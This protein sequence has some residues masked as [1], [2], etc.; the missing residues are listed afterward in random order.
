MK[1]RCAIF[2]TVKNENIFLPIWL[3]HYQQY[4]SNEDI[5]VLDHHST[6]GSTKNLPV[7]VRL[8]SNDTVNDNEWLRNIAQ[9][10]QRELLEKY[11]C[12]IFAESDEILY[13][14][15]KPFDQAIDDFIQSQDLYVTTKGFSVI[16]DIQFEYPVRSGERIFEKRNYWY[17]DRAEDK[18]LITKVPLVWDWGFHAM[19][20]LPN[21][22]YQDFYI[23]HLHRFDFETMVKRHQERTSF[24][25]KNDGGGCHWR[26]KREEIFEVF[27]TISNE[28]MLIPKEHKQALSNLTY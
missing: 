6:D 7:N 1:K 17:K 9:D 13:S 27:Q 24:V 23:A 22:P 18:T 4:F 11:E 20:G 2:T 3:R 15:Q 12:V 21:T 10:F 16:Q 25:Q 14:L 5:Y 19:V 28:P 26:S 8:V